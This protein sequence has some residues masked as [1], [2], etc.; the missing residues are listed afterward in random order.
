M[1]ESGPAALQ[2]IKQFGDALLQTGDL[3]PL[4]IGLYKL[5]LNS[6]ILAKWLVAYWC[7]YHVGVASYMAEREG[8]HLYWEEMLVAARNEIPP[9]AAER[10]PRGAERRH[11]RG[12]KCVRAVEQ[13]SL[14]GHPYRIITPLL[15]PTESQVMAIA[16]SFPMFGPWIAFK[17]AD[18]LET[19]WGHKI[20]FSED[21]G[22]IYAE[23]REALD[24][25]AHTYQK[26]G[27]PPPPVKD[28]YHYL[29]NY[30]RGKLAPPRY[31]R[32]VGPQEVETILCKWKS[33]HKGH[34]WVGKDIK[35]HRAALIGWGPLALRLLEA[36]PKEVVR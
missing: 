6:D 13:L 33:F 3:D 7:F 14:A 35:D 29:R 30:W 9:R 16:Q 5:D 1:V 10:W 34:Y 31:R 32:A 2:S 17:V 8:T 26:P 20:E 36:Y 25:L 12:D 24:I 28:I 4:Y 19:V 23:P 15:Q 22:L 21:I 11:F 27:M 18:M